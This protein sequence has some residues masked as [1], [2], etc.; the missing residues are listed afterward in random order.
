[1]RAGPSLIKRRGIID[2]TIHKAT[3]IGLTT[4]GPFTG[5][6]DA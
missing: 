6:D 5:H 4:I 3:I 2:N 1:M